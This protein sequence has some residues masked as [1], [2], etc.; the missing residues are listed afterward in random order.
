MVLF[1]PF[2]STVKIPHGLVVRRSN[3]AINNLAVVAFYK[4]GILVL[5]RSS[6]WSVSFTEVVMK[7]NFVI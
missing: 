4:G 7:N 5:K 6:I 1:F 3:D 2:G